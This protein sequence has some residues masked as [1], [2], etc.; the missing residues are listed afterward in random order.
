MPLHSTATNFLRT[1]LR[2][3]R[4][5]CGFTQEETAELAGISYIYYQ[6]IEAARRPNPS[7]I[8]IEKIAGA[9]GLK[10][11]ELFSPKLPT[12]KIRQKPAPPPHRPRKKKKMG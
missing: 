2:S 3:L 9:Y 4:E 1:R 10:I 5:T 11:H 8:T 7:L 12:P 6:G